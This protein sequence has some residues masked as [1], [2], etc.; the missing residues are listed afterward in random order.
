MNNKLSKWC[1]RLPGLILMVLFVS[2]LNQPGLACAGPETEK[3]LPEGIAG[4]KK[5]KVISGDEASRIINRMHR[6]EVATSADF[7]VTYE[8]GKHS[9][10]YYLSLYDHPLEAK[11]AMEDMARVMSENGH[12][13]SH[14]MPRSRY[15]INFYMALGQGQAHYFFARNVELVWLAVDVEIAEEAIAEVL[16]VFS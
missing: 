9:A 11:K 6:G 5:E 3:R 4:M 8:D 7:I 14:L 15:G 16:Q 12:G 13:F 2:V 10:T 1:R